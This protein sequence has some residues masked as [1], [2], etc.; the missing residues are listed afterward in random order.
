MSKLKLSTKLGYGCGDIFA[1]G[2]FLLVA[3]LFL[4]FLVNIA[5]LDARLAGIVMLI[6]RFWDAVTDPFMGYLSDRTR[7]RFGRRRLYFLIGIVPVWISFALLWLP[8]STNSQL[9]LFI[10][11]TFAYLLFSTV[12]TLVQVPYTALLPELTADYK[13]RA[14]V[15]GIRLSFS[16]ISAII[17]GTVPTLIISRFTDEGNGHFAMGLIFGLLYALPWLFVFLFTKEN[18]SQAIQSGNIH[19]F[20]DLLSTL[21]NKSF[22]QHAGL[23]I[24]SQTAVDFLTALA[25]FYVIYVLLREKEFVLIMA[26]LLLVPVLM[27]PVW[28]QVA[29]KFEKT[30]PMHVGLLVWALALLAS[31]FIEPGSAGPAIFVVA[32]LSGIGTSASV[33][34]PWSI[35]PEVTDVDE[36]M[37]GFR[38]EG[39]YGGLATFLRKLAGGLA[40][41]LVGFLLKAVGFAEQAAVQ[42]ESAISGI[43]LMFALV[44]TA[45]ILIALIF[46]FRYKV[47]EKNHALL[48][49]AVQSR[50]AG[51]PVSEPEQIQACELLSGQRFDTL[52]VGAKVNQSAAE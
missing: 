4:Y 38:R 33:F 43:R 24:G 14:S 18:P 2:A 32:A 42:P 47:N 29:K 21:R 41:M 52:W 25:K 49:Q 44:P 16:A 39:V 1:G 30:T 46:S 12:F 7:S 5:G 40:L 17:A 20:R 10:Y 6:G 11:Y 36:A 9:L 51:R 50:R 31:L 19:F 13:E 28:I 35:L 15:S 22:R 27:M 37:C 26:A 23:F 34:V 48:Q 8:L 3:L 45:A